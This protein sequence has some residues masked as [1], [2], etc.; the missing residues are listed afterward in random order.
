[1]FDKVASL[2]ELETTWNL[3]DAERAHAFLD[4]RQAM[5]N[6]Q[7]MEAKKRKWLQ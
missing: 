5:E 7:V 2:E 4:V 6:Q 1:M 3:D